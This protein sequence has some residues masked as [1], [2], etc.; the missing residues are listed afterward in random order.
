MR[1]FIYIL[2]IVLFLA[3]PPVQ[4]VTELSNEPEQEELTAIKPTPKQ[5]LK[6]E[7]AKQ[8]LSQRDFEILSAI[9]QAESQWRQF[10]FPGVVLKGKINDKD[11]GLCQIN[12]FWHLSEAEK[13]G[14]DIYTVEGNLKFCVW[15]YKK[16]GTEPWNW[17]KDNWSKK[18]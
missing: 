12:E 7:I 6:I 13:L 3:L 1:N 17:S 10:E 14:L 16:E 15:L 5:F 8:G 18:I 9:I 11:I 2:L 4:Y